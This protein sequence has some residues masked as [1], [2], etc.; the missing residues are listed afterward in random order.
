MP[1]VSAQKRLQQAQHGPNPNSKSHQQRPP[2]PKEIRKKEPKETLPFIAHF[3]HF[4]HFRSGEQID[5]P[6]M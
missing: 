4:A 5:K 6:N 2:T 3:A 1:E